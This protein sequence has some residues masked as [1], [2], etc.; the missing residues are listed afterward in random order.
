MIPTPEPAIIVE[1]S[2]R[3]DPR[4]ILAWILMVLFIVLPPVGLGIVLSSIG[5]GIMT[6]GLTSGVVGY[7][8]GTD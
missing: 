2:Q 3:A 1:N 7:I 8:L 5:W 6:L 4:F